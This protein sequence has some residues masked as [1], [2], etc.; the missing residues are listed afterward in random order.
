MMS[1]TG[2]CKEKD[3]GMF[4]KTSAQTSLLENQFLLPKVKRA[5]LER[6]WARGFRDRVLPL[7][8]EELFRASFHKSQ[9][10]PNKSIRLLVGLHLIKEM[11]DYTDTEVI[12]AL[13][14]SG[15]LQRRLRDPSG[16]GVQGGALA[17]AVFRGR[18][19]G[20]PSAGRAA[21]P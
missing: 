2:C 9:G 12:D 13:C 15:L 1:C 8:D 11:R 20:R 6:S 7:I 18:G 16:I 17:S 19:R 10:R 21:P 5:R 14:L 4:R 3:E